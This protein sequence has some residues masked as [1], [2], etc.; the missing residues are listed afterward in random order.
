MSPEITSGLYALGLSFCSQR[1]GGGDKEQI[2]SEFFYISRIFFV[3]HICCCLLG[4]YIADVLTYLPIPF[5]DIALDLLRTLTRTRTRTRTGC[6]AGRG[7]GR[8]GLEGFSP[9]RDEVVGKCS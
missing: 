9:R 5:R 7:V 2:A 8:F 1:A 3:V 6:F 4:G